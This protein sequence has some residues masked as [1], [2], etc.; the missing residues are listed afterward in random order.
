MRD[1]RD[2]KAMAHALRNALKAKA[3][4]TSHS[5]S[6]ELIAKAFGYDNWNILS[7]K[8][9]VAQPRV[10]DGR[11]SPPA[12]TQAPA[13]TLYCTFCAKSQHD[14]RKLIAGPS[15]TYIC[16]EC[17]VLCND[18][19]EGEDDRAFFGL[20]AADEKG[21][22]QDSPAASEYLGGQSTED[23]V[24]FVE[25]MRRGKQLYRAATQSIQQ[26]LTVRNGEVQADSEILASPRLAGLKDLSR[27]QLLDRLERTEHEL[28]RYG[29]ASRIAV[30]VLGRRRT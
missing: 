13:T 24:S 23:L 21:E 10:T 16:D 26:M 15:S 2:A 14:V 25:R 11:A 30:S 5:E 1:F 19:I 7:A 3:V 12:G 9:E 17:V 20:L 29:E 28:A 8:I 4:E 22:Y 27:E 6:L 18:I